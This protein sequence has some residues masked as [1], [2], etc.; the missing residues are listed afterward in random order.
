MQ[1]GK[2]TK[3]EVL[4]LGITAVFLCGLLL[5]S[6]QDRTVEAGITVETEKQV[7]QEEILPDLSPLNL[8]AATAEE[9]QKLP[10]I[11]EALAE[12]IVRYRTEQGR[13]QT[14]EELMNVSGIGQGKFDAVKELIAVE[15]V[16]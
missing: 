8:N 12:R 13:F 7:S 15:E 4:L 10:G 2:V 16:K 9:L 1:K 6:R 11:G 3:S 14:I 5:L